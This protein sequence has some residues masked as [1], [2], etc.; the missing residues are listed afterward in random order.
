MTEVTKTSETTGFPE[1][2]ESQ[3]SQSSPEN[4]Q[5]GETTQTQTSPETHPSQE[6]PVTSETGE[7]QET[8][9]DKPHIQEPAKINQFRS[10]GVIVAAWRPSEED[11]RRGF[12]VTPDGYEFPTF[13]A[14]PW[15]RPKAANHNVTLPWNVWVKT[16]PENGLRFEL[17]GYLYKQ[18]ETEKSI[19]SPEELERDRFSLRGQLK[20]W[21]T[22]EGTFALTIHPNKDATRKFKPFFLLI[23]GQIENPKKGAFWEVE[24][25][26]EGD[27]LV[28]VE[29]KEVLPPQKKKKGKPKG[30]PKGKF[31][32][33]PKPKPKPK[34]QQS[35]ESPSPSPSPSPSE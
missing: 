23:Q 14:S 2:P 21:N 9:A 19:A 12:L 4:H 35:S 15:W 25:T 30:K 7:S 32:G 24:A 34:S 33:K 10:T 3:S 22:E 17:K 11:S 18:H 16:T 5:P 26:R 6:T 20:F 31:K 28:A 13:I 27:K 8:S 1:N 29:S